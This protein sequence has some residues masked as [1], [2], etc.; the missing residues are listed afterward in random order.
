MVK[1]L[2]AP[3]FNMISIIKLYIN[4]YVKIHTYN[5]IKKY[6]LY[7]ILVKLTYLLCL[8][9]ARD[10]DCSKKFLRLKVSPFLKIRHWIKVTEIC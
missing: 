10:K 2:I 3:D 6:S 5:V 4:I 8:K 1:A 7:T 9:C